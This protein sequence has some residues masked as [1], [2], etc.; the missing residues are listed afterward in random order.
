MEA[1]RAQRRAEPNHW[2]T[3]IESG[4]GPDGKLID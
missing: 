1:E 3:L 2:T 4:Q